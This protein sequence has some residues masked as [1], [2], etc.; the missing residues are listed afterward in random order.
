MQLH[1][2]CAQVVCLR[3]SSSERWRFLLPGCLLVHCT[4]LLLLDK[5]AYRLP[6]DPSILYVSKTVL[7]V[8]Q[9][10]Q[11]HQEPLG[12]S[13]RPLSCSVYVYFHASL[14]MRDAPPIMLTN[15]DVRDRPN[16]RRDRRLHLAQSLLGLHHYEPKRRRQTRSSF[17]DLQSRPGA[18]RDCFGMA[19]STAGGNRRSQKHCVPDDHLP[20]QRIVRCLDLS[21]DGPG[22]VLSDWHCGVFLGVYRRGGMLFVQHLAC[23]RLPNLTSHGTRLFV[24]SHGRC[25]RKQS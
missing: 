19:T 1:Q 25:R 3:E 9:N 2:F 17:P 5:R 12:S 21:G 16:R 23:C 15:V 4:A 10:G 7:P 24:R 8:L 11:A 20:A 18:S 14:K 13:H 22:T 6:E